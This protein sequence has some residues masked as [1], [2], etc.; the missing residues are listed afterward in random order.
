[1]IQNIGEIKANKIKQWWWVSQKNRKPKRNIVEKVLKKA[2]EVKA[3]IIVLRVDQEIREA[4][5]TW[6][7]AKVA[8]DQNEDH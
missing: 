5:K 7:V 4:K 8:I 1:M 6:K 3:Q 2:K